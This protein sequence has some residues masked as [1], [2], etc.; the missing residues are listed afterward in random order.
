[1]DN[2]IETVRGYLANGQQIVGID[3]IFYELGMDVYLSDGS[4]HRHFWT[5]TE[6]CVG[7]QRIC[8]NE[9]VNRAEQMFP[10]IY[11]HHP[12]DAIPEWIAS[13]LVLKFRN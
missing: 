12:N 4:V 5:T 7:E 8:F 6:I 10:Q 3:P 13:H 9:Q 2:V 11:W 1:M